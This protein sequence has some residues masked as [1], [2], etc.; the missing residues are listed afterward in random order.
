MVSYLLLVF[1]YT[2][3]APSLA[4]AIY[5]LSNLTQFEVAYWAGRLLTDAGSHVAPLLLRIALPLACFGI[6][7][8][9]LLGVGFYQATAHFVP[10]TYFQETGSGLPRA[11]SLLGSPG[12]FGSFLMLVVPLALARLLQGGRVPRV[13]NLTL[14]VY[15]VALVASFHRSSWLGTAV[16]C[17]LVVVLYARRASRVVVALASF[18]VV[19][20]IST[21]ILAVGPVIQNVLSLQDFSTAS[22]LQRAAEYV[23][24]ALDNPFGLGLGA[25]GNAAAF[26]GN[27]DAPGL[28]GGYSQVVLQ[29]GWLGLLCFAL[30]QLFAITQLIR[31]TTVLTGQDKWVAAGT[32]G[33][34]AGAIVFN[35]ILPFQSFNPALM[36]LWLIVGVTIS[37]A[38]AV[39]DRLVDSRTPKP[40][41]RVLTET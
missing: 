11:M 3:T 32:A 19:A 34:L 22:H 23:Q 6:L 15:A 28:E 36:L 14:I 1:L 39:G 30:V 24:L 12:Y 29:V 20:L 13:W 18:G 21:Q 5:G 41:D 17:S 31:G 25:G 38:S 26:L 7:Q 9:W 33:V 35:L 40:I 10:D 16:A 4:A 2:P 8:P 37:K 27:A